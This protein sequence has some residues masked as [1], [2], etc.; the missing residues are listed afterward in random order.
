MP[1]YETKR[2]V[3]GISFSISAGEMVGFIGPNG[4][5]KST[6]VKMLSGILVPSSGKVT[7]KG[8]DPFKDRKKYVSQIGVVFG[9]RTQLWWDLPAVD[10]FDLLKEVYK[11]PD[12]VYKANMEEFRE[13]LGLDEFLHRP[14][15]QLS[16][17][18]RMRA[19]IAAAMLHEPDILFFDE[20]TIGLDII[21]KERIRE[22]IKRMNKEKGITMLFTTHDMQDIEK[23][24]ERIMVIDHGKIVCDSQVSDV[25][26]LYGTERKLSVQFSQSYDQIDIPRVQTVHEGG[27]Q[28]SFIF[29]NNEIKVSELIT[30]LTNNYDVQDLTVQEP[31]IETIIKKIYEEGAHDYESVS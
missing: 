31:E 20:P 23:I 18:Q 27:N 26:Q 12:K 11:I 7:V 30:Q 22:F 5:G 9:Q 3:N 19:D 17:G 16:L 10:T 25:R 15:R 14:A 24:C 1:E 29:K 13:L 8:M 4:A 2:A 21:A 28:K 6:T